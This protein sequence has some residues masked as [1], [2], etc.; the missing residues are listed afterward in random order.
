IRIAARR[1]GDAI[2]FSVSDTGVG[3]LLEDRERIFEVFYQSTGEYRDAGRSA[4]TGL[5]LAICKE[6]VEHYGGR[7]RVE[8]EPGKGSVFSFSLPISRPISLTV[9][10]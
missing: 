6:I 10:A 8:S 5:G 9:Q 3:V 7:I 4:G 1:S 2:E